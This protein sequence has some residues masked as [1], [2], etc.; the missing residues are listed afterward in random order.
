KFSKG[1]K[2]LAVRASKANATAR[3]NG[4]DMVVRELASGLVQNVGNVNL[5][6]FDDAGRML[7]YT[8]DAADRNGNGVYVI[9]LATGQS[10]VLSSAA[11]DYDQLTWLDKGVALAAFKGD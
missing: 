10:K 11:A 9:D 5:Y 7:A 2:F 4:A 1:S 8:V 6:D 3:H